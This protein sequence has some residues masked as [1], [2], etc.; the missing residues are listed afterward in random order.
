MLVTNQRTYTV[1]RLS[2]QNLNNKGFSLI[3]TLVS[4]AIG[5]LILS[6]LLS[7]IF[8]YRGLHDSD[9]S[10]TNASS[11]VRSGLDFI[12]VHLRQAGEKLNSSF[13]AVLV[14]DGA[15]VVPDQII[16]RKNILD[17]IAKVCI[18]VQPTHNIVRFAFAQ[19]AGCGFNDTLDIENAWRNH[20]ISNGGSVRAYIY[21]SRDDVGEFFTYNNESVF[22]PG[23]NRR[24]HKGSGNFSRMYNHP[25]SFVYMLEEWKFEVD[26]DDNILQVTLNDTETNNIISGVQ[27]LQVEVV[28]QDGTVKTTF[29]EEDNWKEIQLINVTLE[30]AATVGHES[31][32]R[33]FSSSFYPR[34]ILSEDL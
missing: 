2:I 13:P 17:E 20:R 19:R 22:A 8:A 11:G 31:K 33:S 9:L 3:E 30:V 10:R 7:S 14:T 21:D 1:S 4:I 34:N 5:S 18:A 29:T 32:T 26:T 24:L 23:S 28:M 27:D 15:G 6:G 16:I 12:G 25:S